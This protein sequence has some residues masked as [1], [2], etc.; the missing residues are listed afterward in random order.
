M[1]GPIRTEIAMDAA[2]FHRGPH[3]GLLLKLEEIR[4][5]CRLVR[6]RTGEDGRIFAIMP[7]PFEW[8]RVVRGMIRKDGPFEMV[9]PYELVRADDGIAFILCRYDEFSEASRDFIEGRD[10]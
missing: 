1:T 9:Y 5:W 7:S 10:S 8:V 6:A 3:D 4:Y 2:E